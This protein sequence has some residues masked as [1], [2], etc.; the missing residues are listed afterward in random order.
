MTEKTKI[1]LSDAELAIVQ[2]TE[3]ILTK[4]NTLFF[5]KE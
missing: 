5:M 2:E 4:Q 3:W 1:T